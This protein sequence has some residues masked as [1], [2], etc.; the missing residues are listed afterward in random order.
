M[1]LFIGQFPCYDDDVNYERG[2]T[3]SKISILKQFYGK[4]VTNIKA[5]GTDEFD[6]TPN[7]L[8]VD[9]SVRQFGYTA[10]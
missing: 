2:G 6:F 3:M 4:T 9:F 5:Y 8:G 1:C 10:L 7:L